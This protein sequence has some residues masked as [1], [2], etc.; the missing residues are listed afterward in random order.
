MDFRL[1]AKTLHMKWCI[2]DAPCCLSTAKLGA[3]PNQ[4]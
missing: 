3:I 1:A 2:N 4:I